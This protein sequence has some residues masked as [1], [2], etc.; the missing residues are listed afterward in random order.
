MKK[1]LLFIIL[2]AGLVSCK[3]FLE[4]KPTSTMTAENFYKTAA[5][6]DAA[7]IGAYDELNNQ[8]EVY[9]RGIYLL[10]E[11]PTDNAECGQGV[12]N[13]YIFAIK[14]YTYGPVNDRIETLW[15][16]I[17]KGIANANVAIDKIPGIAMDETKKNRLVAEAKFVRALLYF[18]LVRLFGPVPLVLHQTT[19]L[20]SVNV[21]RAT[22]DA[23]YGQI[24]ADL[25]D[26]ETH[27]DSA[28]TA[29]NN[30]RPS[31]FAASA[32]LSKVYLTLH[33][34]SNARSEAQLVLNNAQYG[35]LPA[36]ADIFAPDNR[37]NKEVLFGI[38]NKGNTGTGNGFAMALFLPRSTIPLPGGGT[39]GGNQADVPTQEFYN[40]FLPGDLRKDKTFFTQYNAGAGLVTFAPAWFKYFD[41]ASITNLGEGS[42][43]FPIV[44]YADVL[45][46][47]AEAENELNGPVAA[48][49][50][51]INQV[52]RRAYGKSI[53]TPDAAIDLAGISQGDLRTALLNER[54]WE[55][56]FEDQR[57]FDLKRTNNLLTLLKAKGLGIQD[58]DTLYPIPQRER[59]VNK[60]L[61]QNGG[62]PQ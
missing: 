53:T 5:D 57:W 54:R 50:E 4:E 40:S 47:Y 42:L 3:K 46:T 37:F 33:D 48:A 34:Y 19:G 7:V 18:N 61:T 22:Q 2:L 6:A 20:D 39:V 13:A 15:T 23:I 1:I 25:K 56:G 45:L 29:A 11:L 41:P 58:Y 52:R 60:Q 30:G 49:L 31:R 28:S 14:N 24:I 26:G 8:S 27:L 10:A 59:D 55:F 32:L 51:A 62:Y 38:Q 21:P 16:G 36:Y 44:R 9:Y 17:Y 12:A 35:L 43:N